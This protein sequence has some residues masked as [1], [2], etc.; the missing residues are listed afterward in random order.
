MA[1]QEIPDKQQTE[2]FWRG[3]WSNAKSHNHEASWITDITSDNKNIPYM[4]PVNITSEV[5]TSKTRGCPT[6]KHQDLTW[7][8]LTGSSTTP[9][10]TNTVTAATQQPNN[11]TKMVG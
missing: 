10:N 9:A 2:E 5:V 7:F 6:G 4:A 3:I 8:T 1:Q 11:N